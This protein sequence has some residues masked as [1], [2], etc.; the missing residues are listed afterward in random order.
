[1]ASMIHR[2]HRIIQEVNR[3]PDIEHA[4]ELIIDSLKQ[5]L[6]AEACTIFLA[7]IDDPQLLVLK[8]SAGLNPDIVGRVERRFGQGLIGTIAVRA[9]SM[10]LIDAPAHKLTR[11]S[12]IRPSQISMASPNFGLESLAAVVVSLVC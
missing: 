7:A 11:W 1:M 4:L 2:L 6:K 10:N 5:D 12:R 3:A 9:E 8:A